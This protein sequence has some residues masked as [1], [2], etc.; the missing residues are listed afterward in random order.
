[1]N[2]LARLASRDWIGLALVLAGFILRLR[3]YLVN[4]S[5]WLDEAMLANN[6]LGRDFAGLFRQLDNDQGAPIGF[7]LLQK[8]ITLA[9]GDSEFALRILPFLAGCLALVL[10][11]L[12]ARKVASPFA[13]SLALA[14]FVF[15]PALIYYASEVKQYSSDVAIAL[16]ISLLFLKY[17][18]AVIK[19][20]D[21]ALLAIVGMLAVGFS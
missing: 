9:L 12:L 15:S 2:R 18:H 4:R 6:I 20:K 21:A 8:T 7:L 16:A 17:E 1:M 11:F 19:Q 10:M 13:G 3:Q 5:L 14:L